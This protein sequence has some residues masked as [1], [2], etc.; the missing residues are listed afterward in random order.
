MEDRKVCLKVGDRLLPGRRGAGWRHGDQGP[1]GGRA[2]AVRAA[3]GR[4]RPEREN[5]EPLFVDVLYL[6]LALII[7]G[8]GF[9]KANISSIV[10][11]LY[12]AGR[13]AP[14][15]GLHP[16][17]LRHQ[18]R[19]VLGGGALRR[20][21]QDLG[22]W[23]GFGAGRRRHAG[24]LSGASCWASRCW[25]ATASRPI[26]SGSKRPILGP[27]TPSGPCTSPALLGV[28]VVWAMLRLDAEAEAAWQQALASDAHHLESVYNWGLSRWRTGRMDG[29]ALARSLRE[30]GQSGEPWRAAVLAAQMKLESDDCKAA[31]ELLSTLEGED[32]RR[33][34]VQRLLTLARESLPTSRRCL[35]TFESDSFEAHADYITSVCLSVDGRYALSGGKD[36]TLCLW[37]VASGQFLRT[38]TGH[39]DRVTSV[40][41]RVRMVATP[42]REAMTRRSGCGRSPAA[43]ACGPLK[44][45]GI[46]SLLSS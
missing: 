45:T 32:A 39:T 11:Q 5:R 8:V 9:L 31:I 33:A 42:F 4:L 44:D 2:T 1:A 43:N 15:S 24:R 41:L 29:V 34:E 28:G 12:P 46:L 21:G 10:G 18:P 19:R 40:F 17:L 20:A 30:T 36:K 38:F 13:S 37:E 3:Q 23:A 26:P 14:R 22:W 25:R 16:L 27:V 7:M 6:A 35:R